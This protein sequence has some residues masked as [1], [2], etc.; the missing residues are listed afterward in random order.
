MKTKGVKINT[1]KQYNL[2]KGVKCAND[3]IH[4]V[5]CT[6]REHLTSFVSEYR[7]IDRGQGFVTKSY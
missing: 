3:V 1:P 4:C 2:Y 7:S 6:S 5:T